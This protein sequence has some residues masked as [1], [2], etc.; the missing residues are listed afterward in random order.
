M[1]TLNKIKQDQLQARKEKNMVSANLLTTL[2][3]EI[4]GDLTRMAPEARTEKAEGDVVMATIKSFLKKNKE[5]QDNVKDTKKVQELKTEEAILTAYMPTQLSK[6][7]LEEIIK[8][9]F[10]TIDVKSKGPV[11][12]FLKQNYNGQYDGKVASEVVT[13]L[14]K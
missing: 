5:S 9:Q 12:A 8:K 11:M 7:Q 14:T 6:I 3:G 1:T 4:Q 13:S 10:P 2:M